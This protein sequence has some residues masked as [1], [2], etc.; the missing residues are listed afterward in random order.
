MTLGSFLSVAVR[1]GE[2]CPDV[3]M[4]VDAARLEARATKDE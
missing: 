2:S 1:L 3:D 4:N